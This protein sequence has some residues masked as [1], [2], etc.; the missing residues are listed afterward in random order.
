MRPAW[1]THSWQLQ[2]MRKL[3][4]ICILHS[5]AYRHRM[6]NEGRWKMLT[7]DTIY[8]LRHCLAS[9]AWS[10]LTWSSVS[11]TIS[12]FV[13]LSRNLSGLMDTVSSFCIVILKL[14]KCCT[15]RTVTADWIS[16]LLS[17]LVLSNLTCWSCQ[18]IVQLF[19]QWVF[20]VTVT[21]GLIISCKLKIRV[22][23][24]IV[25]ASDVLPGQMFT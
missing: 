3:L 22:L 2:R 16:Y 15:S 4:R 8:G 10:Q 25:L 1:K 12:N 14:A 11:Q 19:V 7:D 13:V 18:L 21:V 17:V 24:L 23:F 9:C 6:A 5:L 20:C